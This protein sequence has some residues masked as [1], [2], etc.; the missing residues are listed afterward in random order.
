MTV[1]ASSIVWSLMQPTLQAFLKFPTAE[2]IDT[3]SL[4]TVSSGSLAAWKN[5]SYCGIPICWIVK[6]RLTTGRWANAGKLFSIISSK[7]S[8]G[9]VAYVNFF[10]TGNSTV[11]RAFNIL[12]VW[13][14]SKFKVPGFCFFC[15]EIILPT[16]CS[17]GFSDLSLGLTHLLHLTYSALLQAIHEPI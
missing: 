16:H 13:S 3:W 10:S 2:F 8:G 15:T 4:L 6:S 14:T 5:S 1:I 12:R 7:L 9:V 11:S 17:Y